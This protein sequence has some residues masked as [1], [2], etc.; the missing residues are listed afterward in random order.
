MFRYAMFPSVPVF[1]CSYSI[2]YK[3]KGN[4][5]YF[6]ELPARRQSGPVLGIWPF[7]HLKNDMNMLFELNKILYTLDKVFSSFWP[8]KAAGKN[9]KHGII[10]LYTRSEEHTS[11]LQSRRDLVCRLLLEK[12]KKKKKKQKIE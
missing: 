8:G 9:T 10:R 7:Y 3:L 11:E 2:P 1:P 6:Y 4:V 5:A 12:K